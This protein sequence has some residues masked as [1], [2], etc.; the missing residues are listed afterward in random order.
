M[1]TF[2]KTLLNLVVAL[3]LITAVTFVACNPTETDPEHVCRHLCSVCNKCTDKTCSDPVCAVK[4][5]GHPSTGGGDDDTTP[6]TGDEQT[7]PP[8]T[9]DDQQSTPPST[10]DDEETTPPSTGGDDETGNNTKP[11]N[12]GNTTITVTLLELPNAV[13]TNLE[14]SF[15]WTHDGNYFR[16]MGQ[17]EAASFYLPYARLTAMGKVMYVSLDGFKLTGWTCS[18]HEGVA[19]EA[20]E[21]HPVT[22][23]TTFTAQ[24]ESNLNVP[25]VFD[26]EYEATTPLDISYWADVIIVR[27]LID[28]NTL[29]LYDEKG[30]LYATIVLD[31]DGNTAKGDNG[32]SFSATLTLN[33]DTLT[34]TVKRPIGSTTYEGT[35]VKS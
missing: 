29:E 9:D 6:P 30:F 4:C 33:G 7:T 24:W 21:N 32:T 15:D 8:T 5:D 22:K 19:H 26:G 11:D 2:N 35:F 1:K 17:A 28:G 13:T 16:Q 14:S 18:E 34:I 12:G 23:D 20:G 10:D 27:V 31:I 25:T 3:L